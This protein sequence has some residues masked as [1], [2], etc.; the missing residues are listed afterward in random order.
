MLSFVT[1]PGAQM[2]RYV[3]R[4]AFLK[5]GHDPAWGFHRN[6]RRTQVGPPLSLSSC[7][8]ATHQPGIIHNSVDK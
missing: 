7:T 4:R 5:S 6:C 8:P 3:A 2:A 1:G